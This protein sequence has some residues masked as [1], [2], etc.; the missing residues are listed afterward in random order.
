MN[1]EEVLCAYEKMLLIRVMEE[2]ISALYKGDIIPG[3]VHT[4]IGQ[5]ACA[6]GALTHARVSD[7]ITS[8]HRGHGH[9]LA[10]G[11]E[12]DRMMAELMGKVTGANNGR[13]GSMHVA[14]PRL[15]IFGA[16]GIV[17]AGLPIA[18]GAAFAAKDRG[19][20]DLVVAFFGDGAIATGAFHEA[21]NMAALWKLPIIFLCENNGFSEFSSTADQHPVPI[22]ARA[23]GYGMES[24]TLA[25]NDVEAVADGIRPVY[26]QVRGGSGPVFVEV[27][28][29]RVHGHYEGDPQVYRDKDEMARGILAADPLTVTRGR[30]RE[31]G[32]GDDVLDLV[33]KRVRAVVDEAERFARAS[34][35]PEASSV[36]E[37]IYSPRRV[38]P[39]GHLDVSIDAGGAAVSQ[40]KIIKAALD[41]SLGADP[42]VFLAGIDVAGGNVFGLTR[43]LAAKYP[44][45]VFDTPISESAIMGLAVGS[46]MA[47]RRPVVELMYLDFLGVC[48]D[49]LMNQAAKL[50]FMTG[51]AA[52]LPLVVRT[53]FGSGRSS[54]GQ[55]SQSLEALLAHIPGLTVLM[56]SSGADAYGL[57]RAAIEDDNPVMFIEHRLLY[58]KKNLLPS[59]DFRVPIGKAA[60]TR[61]GSDVTIVSWSRMAMHALIAAQSLA[62]EGIDAEVI[63]L[64]TIA[65]LDRETILESFGRTNRMVIAQEAVVDFGVGAEIAALAVDSGFYSLDAP[66]VR[67]GARYAPAPYA[68]VLERE[69]EVGP[70][71][72]VAAVRRVMSC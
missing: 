28:T 57:L 31:R 14:D 55:H 1:G 2:R 65:P 70:D 59:K 51:G 53:Q 23:A 42:D 5:E 20:G 26:A 37:Y 52:S 13:G 17:G 67:V 60:V 6:V 18:L 72:I 33:D 24:I 10:K 71:D 64:R 16:N 61:P 38:Y 22:S 27:T 21:M 9:V 30:L 15:G 36:M 41:D 66:V 25:G 11:L 56:P 7:V 43:G 32:I 12:P 58:E 39:P 69:W 35:Q 4:S 50:R 47:G 48:L 49:Q 62:D 34:P 54:G 8:T 29:L 44:G 19:E 40:S 63:D 68:P 3:F 45:R 46:A